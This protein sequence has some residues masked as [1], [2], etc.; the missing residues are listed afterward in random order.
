MTLAAGET[1]DTAS[2]AALGKF[3]LT[4]RKFE[5]ANELFA[6]A[7]KVRTERRG[8]HSDW[9]ASLLELA[10][11]D[12]SSGDRSKAPKILTPPYPTS[13]PRSQ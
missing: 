3:L 7:A 13:R 5:Q 8:I 1:D 6:R 9:G 10:R 4:Q 2:Q 11:I 12:R